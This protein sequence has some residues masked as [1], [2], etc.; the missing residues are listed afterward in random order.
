[1]DLKPYN[2]QEYNKLCAKFLEWEM[3]DDDF[4]IRYWKE[5]PDGVSNWYLDEMHFHEDRNW[6]MEVVEKIKTLKETKGS[7]IG[8]TMVTKFEITNCSVIIGYENGDYYGSISIGHTDN[9]KYYKHENDV[10]NTKE[11]VILAI[12]QFLQFYYTNL[13]SK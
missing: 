10:N 11:A 12:W 6:I 8:T 3:S 1:M 7:G 4:G 9:G 13:E 5:S 2:E